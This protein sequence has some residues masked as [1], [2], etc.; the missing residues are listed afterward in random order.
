MPDIAAEH[1]VRRRRAGWPANGRRACAAKGP[2]ERAD[3]LAPWRLRVTGSYHRDRVRLITRCWINNHFAIMH[4]FK[5]RVEL[6]AVCLVIAVAGWAPPSPNYSVI[7]ETKSDRFD[8][9]QLNLHMRIKKRMKQ[10][11]KIELCVLA[12]AQQPV[13]SYRTSTNC[14]V[15]WTLWVQDAPAEIIEK[16]TSVERFQVFEIEW[17]NSYWLHMPLVLSFYYCNN[18]RI[19]LNRFEFLDRRNILK[20]KIKE[21]VI[22]QIK[23]KNQSSV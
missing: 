5:D 18:K 14:C 15:D 2:L 16:F 22:Y 12:G 9:T 23:S 20:N 19:E 17:F 8:S 1:T 11:M 7:T 4:A 21:R 3:R 10:L 13:A 6:S